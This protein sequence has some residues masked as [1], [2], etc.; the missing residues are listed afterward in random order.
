[1]WPTVVRAAQ[2]FVHFFERTATDVGEE[3]A[4]GSRLNGQSK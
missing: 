2:E 1:V 4:A 3:H